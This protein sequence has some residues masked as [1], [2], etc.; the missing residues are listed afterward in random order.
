MGKSSAKNPRR[1]LHSAQRNLFTILA[2]RGCR[3]SLTDE[4]FFTVYR[5]NSRLN[6]FA[7][8]KEKIPLL[9]ARGEPRRRNVSVSEM[10]RSAEIPRRIERGR[11]WS[12]S[13]SL[14]W[15][16][17]QVKALLRPFLHLFYSYFASVIRCATA[18][19]WLRRAPFAVEIRAIV[20]ILDTHF[21]RRQVEA[22]TGQ[23]LAR[24]ESSLS[25]ARGRNSRASVK[26]PR[27]FLSRR[28]R[29]QST[30]SHIDGSARSHD[31]RAVAES[32]RA[33]PNSIEM[34]L[35]ENS[36]IQARSRSADRS[37]WD[38]ATFA[39]TSVQEVETDTFT[40]RA[41]HFA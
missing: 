28:R 26:A 13:L 11:A 38:S 41:F 37:P 22:R 27:V 20:R 23:S 40:R 2:K 25:V 31:P 4:S 33:S 17:H 29:A 12:L 8:D 34:L 21:D 5:L 9:R 7:R 19:A 35:F 14:S 39:A 15:Q 32:N 1:V 30:V 3:S 24:R 36:P 18:R 10:F 16:R 6:F